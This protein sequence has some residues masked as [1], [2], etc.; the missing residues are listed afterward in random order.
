ML[1]DLSLTCLFF[2]H[3]NSTDGR[4]RR[5]INWRMVWT[6]YSC[7][8]VE[9]SKRLG[10][11]YSTVSYAYPPPAQY[12]INQAVLAIPVSHQTSVPLCSNTAFEVCNVCRQLSLFIRVV[13]MS[14]S[15]GRVPFRT[16][17]ISLDRLV[18]RHSTISLRVT[19]KPKG[20]Y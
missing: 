8:G 20:L 16:H 14:T 15:P 5:E 7:T 2:P 12:P 6:K 10:V 3:E 13:V 17:P 18:L 1:E 19:L 4:R 9:V 11:P